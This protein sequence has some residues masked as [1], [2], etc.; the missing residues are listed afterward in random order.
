MIAS[1]IPIGEILDLLGNAFESH[2]AFIGSDLRYRYAND[3]YQAWHLRSPQMIAGKSIQD[4]L[5][6]AEYE[7]LKPHLD[8]ALA[9][10]R[11]EFE[12]SARHPTAGMRTFLARLVPDTMPDGTVNG[13]LHIFR[14]VTEGRRRERVDSEKKAEQEKAER[15]LQASESRFR[16]M[17]DR[18]P[19]AIQI[20][21]SEGKSVHFNE[22]WKRLWLGDPEALKNYSLFEDP[23]LEKLGLTQLF[24][25][26]L[27]GETIEVAA[28]E[29]KPAES[30]LT[31]RPRWISAVAYPV[32]LAAEQELALIFQDV[33]EEREA[34]ME[35]QAIKERLQLIVNTALDAAITIDSEDRITA[36]DGQAANIFGWTRAEVLGQNL[37]ETII[38][39]PARDPKNRTMANL[40]VH[41]GKVL[42]HR[43][44]EI[45]ANHK[46]GHTFP[47]EIAIASAKQ[48]ETTFYIISARDIS[49]RVQS[50]QELQEL[51]SQLEARVEA[52]TTELKKTNEE[53][54][55]AYNKL[56]TFSYSVSHDLRNPLRRLMAVAAILQEDAPLSGEHKEELNSIKTFAENMTR[57]IEDHLNFAKSA[58]TQLQRQETDF[59]HLAWAVAREV[60]E[61]HPRTDVRVR[62]L[63]NLTVSADPLLLRV[64]L[65]NLVEN[66][67]KF[68]Q[69]CPNPVVEIGTTTQEN[70]RLFFVRDNGIGFD[71][72]FSHKLFE[73]FEKLH[74]EEELAGTG[75]GLSNTKEIIERH[76]GKIWAEGIP[77]KGATFFFTLG[78]AEL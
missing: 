45:I 11:D 48:N 67:A 5:G 57:L 68:S 66:G 2:I 75:I 20:F 50:R 14:D 10:N 56:E 1:Q 7:S 17:V 69:S 28:F 34:Q 71:P 39:K 70:E 8:Y 43:R 53:L 9:G 65:E 46:H 31:G 52:R 64:V 32:A 36:W 21:D 37:Y 13:V 23:Q 63:P 58:H 24:K 40:L 42:Q 15:A 74:R 38:S 19:F 44:I 41:K 49:D 30:G 51:N 6:R 33:T 35:V 55:A 77:G 29:Y 4:I 18:S 78:T 62:T 22:A 25:L 12:F 3:A 61:E 73:P 54:A 60:M 76:G 16:T 47:A 72:E 59:S 26:A 27:D